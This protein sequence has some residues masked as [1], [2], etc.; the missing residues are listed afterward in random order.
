MKPNAIASIQ[1]ML[2]RTSPPTVGLGTPGTLWGWALRGHSGVGHSK[3]NLGLGIGGDSFGV[4][5]SRETLGVGTPG[6]WTLVWALQRDS[7]AGHSRDTLELGTPSDTLGLG[8][9][10]MSEE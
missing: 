6:T 7:K 10:G 5:H 4:G 3:E 8:T 2:L 1:I 9:P